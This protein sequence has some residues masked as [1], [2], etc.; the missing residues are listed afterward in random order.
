MDIV[1]SIQV[2]WRDP[3][4]KHRE[5]S[6]LFKYLFR[7][8]EGSP[9]NYEFSIVK[10]TGRFFG[11]PHRHNFDQVRYVLSGNF[12]KGNELKPGQLGYYPEGTPYQID[13]GDAEVLLL[14]FGGSS[15]HGF[16]NYEQLR[17]AHPKLAESGVFEGGI[18]TR[19]DP[20]TGRRN[21]QDGYEAIWEFVNQKPVS[22]PRPRYL[23]PVLLNPD[24]FAWQPT[25]GAEGDGNHAQQRLLGAFTERDTRMAMTRL[26][27][28]GTTTLRAGDTV[29][30][31]YV[32]Q[33]RGALAG[34][35]IGQG[36]ALR[37]TAGET[38]GLTAS[39]DLQTIDI[40]LPR[41]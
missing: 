19:T 25:T 7:G 17:Q 9:Q 26:A 2:A 12:G 33:G 24:N 16:M 30:L 20:V 40:Y 18:Y 23:Q 6:I 29:R 38:A 22:Y 36:S 39:A 8:V 31:S 1:D 37:L 41:F 4:T 5:G 32:T 10:T 27:A 28:G 14:Q 3:G 13:A 15:G 35:E 11:P 34:R 21:N